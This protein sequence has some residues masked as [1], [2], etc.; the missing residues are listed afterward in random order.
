MKL[1][2]TLLLLLLLSCI[3]NIAFAQ[4][5][6]ENYSVAKNS[7]IK[8]HPD[9]LTYRIDLEGDSGYKETTILYKRKKHWV[10]IYLAIAPIA[11]N[12]DP[13][14]KT[15]IVSFP[16][17][18]LVKQLRSF[19]IDS[20]KQITETQLQDYLNKDIPKNDSTLIFGLPSSSHE[21]YVFINAMGNKIVYRGALYSNSI[22]QELKPIKIFNDIAVCVIANSR[23]YNHIQPVR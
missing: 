9:S 6:W 18:S 17:D 11:P 14:A 15:I 3:G 21:H 13:E 10:G 16:A 4:N 23:R 5:I 22:F 20:L 7:L 2:K 1:N 12:L 19:G 8:K